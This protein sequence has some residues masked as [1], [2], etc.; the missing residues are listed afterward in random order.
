M[1]A[2]P[3]LLL[4]QRRAV[5]S[6]STST[7]GRKWLAIRTVSIG[8]HRIGIFDDWGERLTFGTRVGVVAFECASLTFAPE[9]VRT[10]QHG[11]TSPTS[12]SQIDIVDRQ[13]V[14]W[15]ELVF[16]PDLGGERE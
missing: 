10:F 7:A 2:F 16:A 14:A 12:K 5:P 6:T 15:L 9:I 11:S 8:Q 1:A 13:L 3:R 4:T